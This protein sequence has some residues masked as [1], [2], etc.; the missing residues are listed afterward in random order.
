MYDCNC[1]NCKTQKINLAFE[2]SKIK[3]I[4]KAVEI[5]FKHL[6]GVGKYKPED[7][8]ITQEYKDL[9]AETSALF[10]KGIS[11]NSIPEAMLQ[12]LKEDVFLFSSL[13]T[14]AQLSEASKLLLDDNGAVKSF[15][16]FAK[17]ILKIKENYNQNYLE[18]EYQFA[19]S[20][21]QSAAN[22]ATISNDYDLQYR[23][24]GDSHVRDSHDKLRDTTL[25]SDDAFW[26]SYY[27]PNGWRCR[28]TAV[29]VRKG[30]YELS[31][32]KKAISEGDK[33]T[34]QIDKNGKN[35]LEIFRFNPGL[36]KVV[37]PP[38]H[39]YASVQG[40]KKIIKELK[41]GN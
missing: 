10:E 16:K 41:G 33:A 29:Q 32:S 18:T 22:W 4:L 11:D 13:K 1:E 31:D 25:P 36:Q 40:A 12:S 23:T 3:P 17:E 15:S 2:K 27:P 24:A 35:K 34:T 9:V 19:V 30:K 6:H 20:S 5:A 39:P 8:A 14:H 26:L 38:T 7:I 21:A 28:C 37:F